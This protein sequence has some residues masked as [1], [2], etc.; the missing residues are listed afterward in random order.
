MYLLSGKRASEDLTLPPLKVDF[1]MVN[2]DEESV[3][4]MDEPLENLGILEPAVAK[5]FSLMDV[6]A[7][8]QEISRLEEI[9]SG[10]GFQEP[11]FGDSKYAHDIPS[12]MTGELLEFKLEAHTGANV[13]L[14]DQ[15]E[16]E[17]EYAAAAVARA[18]QTQKPHQQPP[19]DDAI[20]RIMGY[21]HYT[22][23]DRHLV[24]RAEEIVRECHLQS[25]RGKKR[26]LRENLSG[27]I[28]E[29]LVDLMGGPRFHEVYQNAMRFDPW[30]YAPPAC[31]PYG[32]VV[33]ACDPETLQVAIAYGM[34]IARLY[35]M[36]VQENDP[37][38]QL[39]L[40]QSGVESF[41]S[42][43]V[44]ERQMFWNYATNP[45]SG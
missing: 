11:G 38:S 6:F 36:D 29:R 33:Q 12:L 23:Q 16:G 34:H 13:R 31:Y 17:D 14:D 32:Y 10:N 2:N 41:I 26:K 35:R 27:S 45:H 39:Q 44:R 42:M 7:P 28:F 30:A 5:P 37:E 9:T 22:E 19:Q 24:Q 43:N 8:E 15:D 20:A 21:L 18:N 3:I 40:V 25:Q 4:E 1:D